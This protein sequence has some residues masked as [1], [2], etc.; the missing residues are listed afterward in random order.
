MRQ[1]EIGLLENNSGAN[2]F[3]NRIN[4]NTSSL[5]LLLMSQYNVIYIYVEIKIGKQR[6]SQFY[7]SIYTKHK[8]SD[9]NKAIRFLCMQT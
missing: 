4:K 2:Q 6:R 7:D 8:L 9:I 1:I 3:A 5:L